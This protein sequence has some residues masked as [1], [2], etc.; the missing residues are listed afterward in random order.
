MG[1]LNLDPVVQA[2]ATPSSGP[3][4][5]S[6]V[7]LNHQMT[8]LTPCLSPDS[9]RLLKPPPCPVVTECEIAYPEEPSTPTPSPF[10]CSAETSPSLSSTVGHMA[11]LFGLELDGCRVKGASAAVDTYEK[12]CSRRSNTNG[13][14][15]MDLEH[16]RLGVTSDLVTLGPRTPRSGWSWAFKP[17]VGTSGGILTCWTEALFD[18]EAE[19]I[20]TYSLIT[21]LRSRSD[22]F[23]WVLA[24]VY[25]PCEH[26]LKLV[27]LQELRLFSGWWSLPFCFLGDFN[28]IRA[29]EDST[30]L[31]PNRMEM[32][33]FNEWCDDLEM[34]ELPLRG[35]SF[36]WS[37]LRSSPA[38]SRIDRVFTSLEWDSQYPGFTLSSQ[39][40]TCSDHSPLIVACGS[41]PRVCRPWRFENMWLEHILFRPMLEEFWFHAS[42]R[43]VGL[44]ELSR[45]LRSLKGRLKVWNSEVFKRIE[46]QIHLKLSGIKSLDLLEEYG[47]LSESERI[48]RISLKCELDH[49]WKLEENSWAQKAKESWLRLGD[50]NTRFFHRVAN[51]KRRFNS[52]DR[53]WVDGT[54]VHGQL[55]LKDTAV[56]F[57]RSLYTDLVC[58]RPFPTGISFD[59]IPSV[60]SDSLNGTTYYSISPPFPMTTS[61]KVQRPS[62][63]HFSRMAVFR[64]LLSVAPWWKASDFAAADLLVWRRLVFDNG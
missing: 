55:E 1:G 12:A 50:K 29:P 48:L 8:V 43:A 22:E 5:L 39:T 24:N 36:T 42:G 19:W 52:I 18:I 13:Q 31:S 57:Y 47:L 46:H 56:H 28:L 4:A 45:K 34:I 16:R 17:A 27:F 30:S 62:V 6:L 11:I 60:D 9:S 32:S 61:R 54:K 64:S 15:R 7:C 40:R 51:A 49:L 10:L 53:I 21:V 23:S 26:S 63:G 14:S 41:I 38:Q 3:E 2:Q 59:S 37:N 58:S 44:L 35:A 20:G 33:W 25:G